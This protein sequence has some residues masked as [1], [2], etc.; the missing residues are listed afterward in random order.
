MIAFP[1]ATAFELGFAPAAA[2]ILSL[3]PQNTLLLRQGLS[4]HKTLIVIGT[5]YGSDLGL[6]LLG[7]MGLGAVVTAYPLVTPPL[8]G[9][10]LG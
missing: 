3:G 5:C 8:I 10:L 2:A 9:A 7:T 4:G 1:D 6:V